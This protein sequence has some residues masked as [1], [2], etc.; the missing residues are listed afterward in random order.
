MTISEIPKEAGDTLANSSRVL[1]NGPVSKATREHVESTI[2]RLNYIPESFV[3]NI[4]NTP[5]K[6]IAVVT[7]G[8]SNYFSMEFA[9][10]VSE[11]YYD[12]GVI[13]YLCCNR[14]PQSE[15]R[16][17]MDLM[18]RGIDGIILHD[19]ANENYKS[20]IYHEITKRV[21]IVVVHSFPSEQDFN[22]ITVDQKKG[23]KKVM[24]YLLAQGHKDIVFIRGTEEHYSMVLKEKIWRES[25]IEGGIVPDPQNIVKIQESDTDRAIQNTE[26]VLSIFFKK[27]RHPTAIFTCNDLIG[28]G[29]LNAARDQGFSIP[30][31]ISII[32]HDNTTLAAS[33][34]LTTVDMKISSVANAA[35]DLMKYALDGKDVTPRHITITPDL[36]LRN[37]VAKPFI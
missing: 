10:A 24:Q 26:D 16:N 37:S 5:T 8:L 13:F 35:V 32:S 14:D 18:A 28:I 25:L 1:N 19:P 21:P 23:M 6:A 34:R 7:H 9:E 15:Y 31:D 11:R 12:E 27:G 2:L 17:L 4:V 22:S 20:G 33:S 36:V 3:S 29:A 30:G